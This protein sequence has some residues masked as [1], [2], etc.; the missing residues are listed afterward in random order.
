MVLKCMED[1]KEVIKIVKN[2]SIPFSI[3]HKRT[4]TTY[5]KIHLSS[6]RYMRLSKGI[7]FFKGVVKINGTCLGSKRRA[8][9]SS[10]PGPSGFLNGGEGI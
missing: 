9:V 1:T 2:L 5:D 3:H 8:I 7:N 4:T 6:V 10:L